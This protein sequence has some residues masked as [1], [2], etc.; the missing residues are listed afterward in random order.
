MAEED[1]QLVEAGNATWKP[2][3]DMVATDGMQIKLGDTT[4]R[5]VHTPGHTP[6]TISSIFPVRD[7]GR[8]HV[9]ALWGGTMFNVPNRPDSPRDHWLGQYSQ[10]AQK[11]R[12]IARANGADVLL[13]NHTRFDAST[14]KMPVLA[15][16]QPGQAHP[17][18][19]GA[20]E[21]GKFL[22]MAGNCAQATRVA[23]AAGAAAAR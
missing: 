16:R 22:T 8:Q 5:L 14:V 7:N 4:V 13:S 1:W 20:D 12:E 21:V 2:R 17:Y 11:F 15:R 6:G 10:S 9:A 18:V 23:E 3:R 19:I